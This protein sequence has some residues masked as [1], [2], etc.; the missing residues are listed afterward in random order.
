MP[1]NHRKNVRN[2]GWI[3]SPI[4]VRTLDETDQFR[5]QGTRGF[6]GLMSLRQ[7]ELIGIDPPP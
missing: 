4:A 2:P 7:P 5:L 3:A 6:G 1:P